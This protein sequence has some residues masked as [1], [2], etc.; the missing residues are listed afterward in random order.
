MVGRHRGRRG[1]AVQPVAV[2]VSDDGGPAALAND[3][4]HRDARIDDFGPD[5]TFSTANAV[6]ILNWA[7]TKAWLISFWALQREQRRVCGHQGR[8]TCSGV[9]QPTWYFSHVFEHFTR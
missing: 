6:T 4:D 1:R 8:G 7:R 2:A 5:E 3:R 9:S